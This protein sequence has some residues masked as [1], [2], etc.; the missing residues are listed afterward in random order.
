[1]TLLA[2][3]KLGE[4]VSLPTFPLFFPDSLLKVSS[5]SCLAFGSDI[6]DSLSSYS[7][8]SRPASI[9][10]SSFFDTPDH[11]GQEFTDA[12][13]H[14]LDRQLSLF[15]PLDAEND[16]TSFQPQALKVLQEEQKRQKSPSRDTTM[17]APESDTREAPGPSVLGTQVYFESPAGSEEGEPSEQGEVGDED[18]PT[19]RPKPPLS[20]NK[21]AALNIPLYSAN[22]DHSMDGA[23]PMTGGTTA[24]PRTARAGTN[25]IIEQMIA[26]AEKH[27][28]VSRDY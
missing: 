28:K 27:R 7:G 18:L 15:A 5:F 17:Q 6:V 3:Q 1:M 20:A 9:A 14:D 25:N 26:E 23:S 21:L 8:A 2:S 24:G 13:V 4:R 19:A 22:R 16:T 12:E 10:G 11:Q